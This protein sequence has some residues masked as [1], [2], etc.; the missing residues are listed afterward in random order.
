MD[1]YK[2]EPILIWDLELAKTQ[3]CHSRP[4]S[5]SLINLLPNELIMDF[6]CGKGYY[7]RKLQLNGFD[8][9]IGLEGTENIE[10]ISYFKPILQQDLSKEFNLNK[11]GNIIC[12]EV[13]EHLLPDQ[14]NQLIKNIL[15][16]LKGYLIISWGVPGQGGCGHN[17]CRSNEY[18][19]DLFIKKGL[20]F[21]PK[22]TFHFRDN[23][24]NSTT[25]FKNTI[26]IFKTND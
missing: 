16:H 21:C 20:K 26:F 6:G 2:I 25:W 14:E 9:L 15:N 19:Y 17:N 12:L 8:N 4:L 18:V 3:H 7:L 13:A 22:E 23:I 5:K 10:E 24:T 11:K 1:N